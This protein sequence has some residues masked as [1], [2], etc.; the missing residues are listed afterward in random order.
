VVAPGDSSYENF[1]GGCASRNEA[2]LDL[3]AQ[4]IAEPLKLMGSKLPSLKPGTILGVIQATRSIFHRGL[5]P[6]IQEIDSIPF[7][8]TA[9]FLLQISIGIQREKKNHCE[10][11]SLRAMLANS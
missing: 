3:G 10:I 1:A 9:N 5:I 7:G 8:S 4:M 11:N 6:C 2:L